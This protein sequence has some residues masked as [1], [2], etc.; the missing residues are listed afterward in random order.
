MKTNYT[1]SVVR[2]CAESYYAMYCLENTDADIKLDNL[3]TNERTNIFLF[4]CADAFV[5]VRVI[6]EIV[7]ADDYDD[8]ECLSSSVTVLSKAQYRARERVVSDARFKK[9]LASIAALQS[10]IVVA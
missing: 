8:N 4:E 2:D 7:D 9:D 6:E 1:L 5:E 10:L 3:L